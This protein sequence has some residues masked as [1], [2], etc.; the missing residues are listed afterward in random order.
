MA[1]RY[2]ESKRNGAIEHRPDKFND[3]RQHSREP[4]RFDFHA[5]QGSSDRYDGYNARRTQEMQ[6]AGMIQE[7][8]RAIANMPQEVMI[9]PYPMVGPYLPEGLDDTIRG[10]DGQMSY[11]D[12]KRKEHFFPKKV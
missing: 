9:K 1:K 3:E 8:P 4:E 5:D 6:D 12:N 10:V 11:D 7:D 2:Y